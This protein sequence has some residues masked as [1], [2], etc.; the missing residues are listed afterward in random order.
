MTTDRKCFDDFT[1]WLSKISDHLHSEGFM[2]QIQKTEAGTPTIRMRV[3]S[4][5][6][7]GEL[8]AWSTGAV[9]QLVID[10]NSGEIILERDGNTT[11]SNPDVE[12]SS[13]IEGLGAASV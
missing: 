3:E 8:T 6:R 11:L 1:S 2:V 12:F 13:F 7:I 5:V 4:N 10:L 9:H